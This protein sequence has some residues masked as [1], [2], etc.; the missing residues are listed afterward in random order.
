MHRPNGG[1]PFGF[2]QLAFSWVGWG[3]QW[4]VVLGPYWFHPPTPHPTN[5]ELVA[6]TLHTLFGRAK[7]VSDLDLAQFQGFSRVL[8]RAPENLTKQ[9]CMHNMGDNPEGGP[10][11]SE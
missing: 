8:R 5:T 9:G 6:T 10:K 1:T 11:S 7:S 4:S 2:G 3:S